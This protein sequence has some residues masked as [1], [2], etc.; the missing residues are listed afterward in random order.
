MEF[1]KSVKNSRSIFI[2]IISSL[3]LGG[4]IYILYRPTNLIIFEFFNIIKFSN[5]VSEARLKVLPFRANLP[6]WF[7]FSLP[8][9]LWVYSFSLFFLYVWSNTRE[10]VF[11]F[12]SIGIVCIF[13]EILQFLQIIPGTFSWSDIFF[14]IL[15]LGTSYLVASKYKIVFSGSYEQN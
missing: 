10:Q 4:T 5:I 14:I 6:E 13:I 8:N 2:H 15:G 3:F 1:I 12:I 7:I 9:S 11:T